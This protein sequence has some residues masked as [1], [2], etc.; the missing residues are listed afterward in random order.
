MKRIFKID[1]M[2]YWLWLFNKSACSIWIYCG[3]HSFVRS[4]FS[5]PC[6]LL[7]AYISCMLPYDLLQTLKGTKQVFCYLSTE[8][9][10][11]PPL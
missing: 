2:Y 8:I 6:E 3:V 7:V 1:V 5:P 11:V 10:R 9:N 4:K